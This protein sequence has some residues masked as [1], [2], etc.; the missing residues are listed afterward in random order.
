MDEFEVV[1]PA[2]VPLLR[3]GRSVVSGELVV[4]GGNVDDPIL[5]ADGDG[6]L[7][8]SVLSRQ[9]AG[10]GY[11][12]AFLLPDGRLDEVPVN[13]GVDEPRRGW[14]KLMSELD[15]ADPATVILA[16][17]GV[18]EELGTVAAGS[19]LCRQLRGFVARHHHLNGDHRVVLIATDETGTDI[20][21]L[22]GVTK[23]ILPLPNYQSRLLIITRLVSLLDDDRRL[24][25]AAGVTVEAFAAD[26]EGL[27]VNDLLLAR[28]YS[29][30]HGPVDRRWVRRIKLDRLQNKYQQRVLVV[31]EADWEDGLLP[32]QLT[33]L[34]D[35]L[36]QGGG[37]CDRTVLV[38]ADGGRLRKLAVELSHELGIPAIETDLR[39]VADLTRAM[40]LAASLTPSLLFV[41]DLTR[42][43]RADA[44]SAD[45]EA[46]DELFR[47]ADDRPDGVIIV[48]TTSEPDL[49]GSSTLRRF[50]I[51]PV[52]AEPAAS[53]AARCAALAD[54]RG[55]QLDV[56]AAQRSLS[57]T[58]RPISGSMISRLI[59][60][61]QEIA[62]FEG[63]KPVNIS[64]FELALKQ[65]PVTAAESSEEQVLVE[66]IRKMQNLRYLP[67]LDEPSRQ[68]DL[69]DYLRTHL[70]GDAS[71]GWPGSAGK[72]GPSDH[73]ADPE[74]EF[75]R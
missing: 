60:R 62:D 66:A 30:K 67:W 27:Y 46:R 2:G 59:K 29:V 39:S 14:S 55:W 5:D 49:L 11:R 23:V 22:P 64:H 68:D 42:P 26:T 25:L 47:F 13:H 36:R 12:T 31:D 41:P 19:A 37:D 7:L 75:V 71:G 21:R 6:V 16:R 45:Q 56:V 9:F 38:G 74:P 57:H 4:V 3:A 54:E 43:D 8:P 34:V 51:V 24:R 28:L 69:S 33:V 61:T 52:A 65:L 35:D 15:D 20:G 17:V 58:G 50:V 10:Y 53:T 40:E 70:A 48:A 18:D 63:R 1:G 44:S 32:R 73:G 72:L